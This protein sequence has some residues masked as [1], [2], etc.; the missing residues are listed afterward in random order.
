MYFVMQTLKYMLPTVIVKGIPSINRAVINHQ[1]KDKSKFEL[2]VEGYGLKEVMT[3]PGVDFTRTKTN[4]IIEIEDVLGIEAARQTI[5][6]EIR[7]TM[8]SHGSMKIDIRH[9]Q[10]LADVMTFKGKVLGI[11]RH[12]VRKMTSSTLTLAGFEQT[13]DHLY[14]AAVYCKKDQITGVSECIITGNMA[15]LGTGAFELCHDDEMLPEV[16]AGH[17]PGG[18]RLSAGDDPGDHAAERSAA[19]DKYKIHMGPKRLHSLVFD[20]V[21]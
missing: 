16:E 1:E 6:N 13:T 18:L 17:R 20:S 19:V 12:G 7:Y 10:L 14:D 11:T 5:I 2:L 15:T 4:H 8:E 3:T 21:A 9:V